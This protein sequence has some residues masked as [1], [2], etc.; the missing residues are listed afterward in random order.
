VSIQ[1]LQQEIIEWNYVLTL[2]IVQVLH[3]FVAVDCKEITVTFQI[4]YEKNS[5]QLIIFVRFI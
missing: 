5:Y 1:H 3:S 4:L 2:H